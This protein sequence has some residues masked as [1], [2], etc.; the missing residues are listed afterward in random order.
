MYYMGFTSPMQ[1]GNFEGKGRPIVK[2][3]AVS[4]AKTAEPIEMPFGMWTRV[5][6]IKHVLDGDTYWSNLVN[7]TEPSTCGGD[8]AFFVKLL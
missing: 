5:G 4:S 7:T 8:A 6:P 3:R 1:R 2:Y